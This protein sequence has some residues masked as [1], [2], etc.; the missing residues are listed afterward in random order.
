M[1]SRLACSYSKVKAGITCSAAAINHGYFFCAEKLC[2]YGGID[3][4][5]AP[6]HYDDSSTDAHLLTSFVRG[7][8][9]AGR[10]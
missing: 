6:A 10:Q 7:D 5:V 9:I 8:E 4:G 2:G 1:P 3:G